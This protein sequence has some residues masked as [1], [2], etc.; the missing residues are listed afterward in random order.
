MSDTSE[1]AF[2]SDRIE[3]VYRSSTAELFLI[4]IEARP[5]P[6]SPDFG[7]AG[8]AFV[9]CWVN[10][11]DL[12][13][14]ERRAVALIESDGWRPRRFDSWELVTRGTYA[15]REPPTDGSPDLRE[16]VEQAFVDGEV[17]I[18]HTWL[19]DAPDAGDDP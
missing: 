8:G 7:E 4:T 18:F 19:V 14:A 1:P 15:D 10:A 9:T 12:R 6:E 3:P 2:Y 11:A 16:M 17:C 5:E 13:Q